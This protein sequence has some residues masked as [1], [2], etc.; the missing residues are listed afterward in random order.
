MERYERAQQLTE[1]QAYGEERLAAAGW[2]P[3]AI[4]EL[5]E[6]ALADPDPDAIAQ[7]KLIVAGLRARHPVPPRDGD[8]HPAAQAFSDLLHDES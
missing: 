2:R 8:R 7:A 3:L 5:V 4:A 6:A 1:L